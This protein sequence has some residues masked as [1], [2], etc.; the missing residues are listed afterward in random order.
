MVVRSTTGPSSTAPPRR[1]QTSTKA[2]RER[3]ETGERNVSRLQANR[4]PQSFMMHQLTN[5]GPM[6]QVQDQ[7]IAIYNKATGQYE[8]GFIFELGPRNGGFVS[9]GPGGLVTLSGGGCGPNLIQ[10][11]S[12]LVET[13]FT[14]T[15]GFVFMPLLN[16][17]PGAPGQLYQVGGVVH[18]T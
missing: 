4:N 18:V 17:V 2:L 10:G 13:N 8:P 6:S 9:V 14:F 7:Q 1:P 12:W 5:A 16:T 11:S 15:T 3:V